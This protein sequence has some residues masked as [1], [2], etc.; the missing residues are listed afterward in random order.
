MTFDLQ[1]G[2]K[3]HNLVVQEIMVLALNVWISIWLFLGCCNQNVWHSKFPSFFTGSTGSVQGTRKSKKAS[4]LPRI[5]W[6]NFELW[7]SFVQ[8]CLSTWYTFIFLLN[9]RATKSS[10]LNNNQTDYSSLSDSQFLFGSQFCPES[11]QTLST[12]LDSEVHL[13][14]PKQSQQNSLDVSL[15]SRISLHMFHSHHGDKL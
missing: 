5:F 14:H 9:F 4:I 8:D 7:F 6:N 3:A 2:V 12:A 13:R 1:N 10:N 15:N 11:S